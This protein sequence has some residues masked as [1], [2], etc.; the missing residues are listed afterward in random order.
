[1]SPKLNKNKKTRQYLQTLLC[2]L[3]IHT[4]NIKTY[5][6]LIAGRDFFILHEKFGTLYEYYNELVDQVA[7]RII[8]LQFEPYTSFTQFINNSEVRETSNLSDEDEILNELL[9]NQGVVLNLLIKAK[10]E[11]ITAG[12]S[13]TD[14][15]LQ[16]I[17]YEIQKQNWQYGAQ[18]NK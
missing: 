4:A 17:I 12:D 8:A 1:M 14:N 13:E 3:A 2:T 16:E 5:H 9:T 18:L 7:E 6:W 10:A 15:K 11:A